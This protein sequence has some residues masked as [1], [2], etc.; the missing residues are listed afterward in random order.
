MPK[1]GKP[2]GMNHVGDY[3][4]DIYPLNSE[5][6]T[7]GTSKAGAIIAGGG[8]DNGRAIPKIPLSKGGNG[9]TTYGSFTWFEACE[10]AQSHGKR[11]LTYEEFTHVAYGVKENSSAGTLDDG[12][13][14]H[15][16]DYTSRYM[17]QATGVQWL[18]SAD[19]STD[20]NSAFA[21]NS[22]VT[23]NRGSLYVSGNNPKAALLGGNRGNG[24]TSGSRCSLWHNYLWHAAWDIGS[25]FACD[26]ENKAKQ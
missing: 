14:K 2:E 4:V 22:T 5:H 16:A 17:E 9:T 3:W 24:S 11:L 23:E 1:N 18:W 19:I 20:E 6:I 26:H 25:R 10:I 12:T 21:W 13:T 8:T 15:I 7:N